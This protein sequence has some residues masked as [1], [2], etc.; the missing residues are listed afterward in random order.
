MAETIEQIA[1]RVARKMYGRFARAEDTYEPHVEFAKALVA[2][3][4]KQQEPV[5]CVADFSQQQRE[6]FLADGYTLHDPV[7]ARPDI[8][9]PA[10]VP[11]VVQKALASL[12]ATGEECEF[13][14]M[15][16]MAFP[17]DAWNDFVATLS[18]APVP[19]IQWGKDVRN[20]VRKFGRM[21]PEEGE[22]W[23]SWYAAAFD[24]ME[25][26]IDAAMAPSR[27]GA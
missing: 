1:Q 9:Q 6:L 27:E 15:G 10:V 17:L 4:T 24:M 7:Y 12:S 3:L 16:G 13:N 21:E 22:S 11:E 23:E 20:I 8:P 26:E 2:E 5:A 25:V 14:D 19:A 18:A